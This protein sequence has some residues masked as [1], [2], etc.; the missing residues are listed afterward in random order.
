MERSGAHGVAKGRLGEQSRAV[1]GIFHVCDRN[2]GVVHAVIDHRVHRHRDAV[3][4]QHLEILK[5]DLTILLFR[6][7]KEGAINLPPEVARR[8]CGYAGPPWRS[9]PRKAG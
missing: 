4:G 3:F 8:R 1:V 7:K 6:I 5:I 2:G 9:C